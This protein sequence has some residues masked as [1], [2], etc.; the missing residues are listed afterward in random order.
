MLRVFCS[1]SPNLHAGASETACSRLPR[2]D[3]GRGQ[4]EGPNREKRPLI[5][6]FSPEFNSRQVLSVPSPLCSLNSGDKEQE[7]RNIKTSY[8]R[9]Q[10]PKFPQKRAASRR[11]NVPG[12]L[13]EENVLL[14]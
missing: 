6:T 2:A 1:L 4:G 7:Q 5:L 10:L 3:W 9:L 12:S 13:R 8:A 11:V 14:E